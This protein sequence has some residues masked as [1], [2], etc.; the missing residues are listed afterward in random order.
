M[1]RRPEEGSE[2]CKQVLDHYRSIANAA[3]DPKLAPKFNLAQYK[4]T[5]RTEQGVEYIGR[6][7]MMWRQ[8]AIEHWQ[9]TAGGSLSM[10]DAESKW[11]D[12]AANY[13]DRK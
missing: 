2:N 4:E 3:E 11:D 6:G 13:K 8:Q 7:T 1:V 10:E 5:F 12:W 9:S